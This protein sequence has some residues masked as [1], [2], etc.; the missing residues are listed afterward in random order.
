MVA[1]TLLSAFQLGFCFFFKP[2]LYSLQPQWGHQG[3]RETSAL[4]CSFYK[5]WFDYRESGKN[6]CW[7]ID[8][9]VLNV[10]CKSAF[11]EMTIDSDDSPV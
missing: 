5:G 8:A 7:E 1:V 4:R 3:Q 2:L 9:R 11:T 6:I 10:P